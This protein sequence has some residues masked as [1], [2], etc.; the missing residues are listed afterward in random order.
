[1]IHPGTFVI[2]LAV[3]ANAMG[4]EEKFKYISAKSLQLG[5]VDYKGVVKIYYDGVWKDLPLINGVVIGSVGVSPEGWH[6]ATAD[7]GGNYR[8][9]MNIGAWDHLGW[10]SC[11]QASAMSNNIVIYRCWNGGGQLWKLGAVRNTDTPKQGGD[12]KAGSIN[13]VSIGSDGEIWVVARDGHVYR[14]N[15]ASNSW[16]PLPIMN[17]ANLEVEN[18]NRAIVTTKTGHV[19]IWDGQ[20]FRNWDTRGHCAK[21]ATINEGNAYFIDELGNLYDDSLIE[22]GKELNEAV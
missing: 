12:G 18:A 19:Y 9:N 11:T 1:M 2:L 14:K 6:H 17:A 3:I 16:D 4:S 8:Y 20:N 10:G 22:A 7:N 21:Q 5:G 15:A 13:W